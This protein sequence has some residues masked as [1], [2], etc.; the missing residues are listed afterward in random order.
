MEKNDNRYSRR[1]SFG[2]SL[3]CMLL[4]GAILCSNGYSAEPQDPGQ[5]NV[6]NRVEKPVQRD[7]E[8]YSVFD[9]YK[10][11]SDY[12]PTIKD[13]RKAYGENHWKYL[14]KS[15]KLEKVMNLF[16]SPATPARFKRFVCAAYD[17]PDILF[18]SFSKDVKKVFLDFCRNYKGIKSMYRNYNSIDREYLQNIARISISFDY[19]WQINL[20]NPN[21]SEQ[22]L[23]FFNQ[24][25]GY[26]M[27]DEI[28]NKQTK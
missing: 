12:N 25:E 7:L 17:D 23:I 11:N 6:V 8:N 16:E 10:D 19:P 9:I 5:K 2:R 3:G 21:K 4:G 28:I 15:K 24:M 13:F 27:L 1:V 20:E 14:E 26:R 22:L 18:N